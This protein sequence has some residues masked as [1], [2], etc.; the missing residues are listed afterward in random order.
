MLHDSAY[1]QAKAA[2]MRPIAEVNVSV[3]RRTRQQVAETS[4][5]ANL[6]RAAFRSAPR[7]WCCWSGAASAGWMRSVR[8]RWAHAAPEPPV[9]GTKPVQSGDCAQPQKPNC[10]SASAATWLLRR[11][12]NG[13]DRPDRP[14]T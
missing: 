4:L 12:G 2:I 14:R 3:D 9:F 8:K 10:S 5:D 7:C 13:V 11:H 1:H 6:A